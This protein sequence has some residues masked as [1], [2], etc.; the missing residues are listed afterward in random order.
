VRGAGRPIELGDLARPAASFF[1]DAPEGATTPR[2]AVVAIRNIV[3][4]AGGAYA[5]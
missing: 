3:D 1:M 5:A 4:A 2:R